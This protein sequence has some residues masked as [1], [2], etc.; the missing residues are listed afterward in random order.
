MKYLLI[1]LLTF[2]AAKADGQNLQSG[3]VAYYPFNG[4]VLDSSGNN[5]HGVAFGNPSFGS[6]KWGNNNFALSFDGNNDYILVPASAAISPDTA[7]SIAFRF[8][9]KD[10]NGHTFISKSSWI[11]VNNT[12]NDIQYQIGFGF[13][14]F[15]GGAGLFFGTLHDNNCNTTNFLAN[16]YSAQVSPLDSNI[17]YCAAVTFSK[18]VKKIYLN[19]VLISTE[20]I[21]GYANNQSV[22]Y[23]TNG[24]LKFGAWW[25]GD[26]LFYKGLLDEI[27]VYNR[28][29]TP[30]DVT[31]YCEQVISSVDETQVHQQLKIYPNPT[32]S[33]IN[34]EN[35]SNKTLTTSIFNLL[36]QQLMQNQSHNSIINIDVSNLE[37]G[38]YIIKSNDEV[39]N[40]SYFIKL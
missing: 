13:P 16:H 9:T 7:F 34:I 33:S 28:A 17:W 21:S 30:T 11:G 32:T 12:T 18:G 3:L 22:N 40:T 23:C 31:T 2:F 14:Q 4:N 29:L 19:A 38:V 25:E 37:P 39:N 26:P 15:V 24:Q 6:D 27:R 5:H 36:G 8:K 20:T 35:K 1:S 10:L